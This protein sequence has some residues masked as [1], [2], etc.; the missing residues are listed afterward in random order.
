MTVRPSTRSMWCRSIS[1]WCFIHTSLLCCTNISVL[2]RG[3]TGLS[4]DRPQSR[5]QRGANQLGNIPALLPF[6]P[7]L[8]IDKQSYV[9]SLRHSLSTRLPC[10]CRYSIG[11]RQSL[12]SYCLASHTA[13]RASTANSDF[14]RPRSFK[15]G[16]TALPF[17]PRDE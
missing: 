8:G 10:L 15:V 9:R 1:A 5:V 11:A 14:N 13:N 7:K 16:S 6:G 17:L 4:G 2:C 12:I 3:L